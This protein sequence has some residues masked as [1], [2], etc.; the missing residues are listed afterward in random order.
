MISQ[1]R[2]TRHALLESRGSQ[3]DE[4]NLVLPTAGKSSDL[5]V[6]RQQVNTIF[7]KS[8]TLI[9]VNCKA[10]FQQYLKLLWYNSSAW[11]WK[12]LM[13]HLSEG[14]PC[15]GIY[16]GI[17]SGIVLSA[18]SELLQ[19]QYLATFCIR[20]LGGFSYSPLVERGCAAYDP[21]GIRAGSVPNRHEMRC[22][23]ASL[24][25]D[26]TPTRGQPPCTRGCTIFGT[27][28]TSPDLRYCFYP[29]P[30]F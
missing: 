16:L 4:F 15:F 7:K 26:A 28:A 5:M 12:S 1:S 6:I 29:T 19:L 27:Q 30:C 20:L 14:Y 23:W 11:Y 21:S 25:G 10:D 9:S 24:P 17:M 3:R 2:C 18:I 22:G 13:Q 8:W